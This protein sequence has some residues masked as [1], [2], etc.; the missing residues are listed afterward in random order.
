VT[1]VRIP[2][3]Q[4]AVL[5]DESRI[6][7]HYGDELKLNQLLELATAAQ[8]MAGRWASAS[9][10]ERATFLEQRDATVR[11]GDRLMAPALEQVSPLLREHFRQ[12]NDTWR[13]AREAVLK[14]T[15]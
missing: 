4:V 1:R 12:A 2:E 14:L 10:D 9:A 6:R 15:A 13:A 7:A 8:E 11:Y 3:A 5:G